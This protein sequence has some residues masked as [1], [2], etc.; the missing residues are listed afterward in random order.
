MATTVT[1]KGSTLTS[2]TNQTK[3]LKTAGKYMEDDVTITDATTVINNQDKGVTPIE[4]E[5]DIT[6]DTGYTGLG[7]VTV[8]A[9][10]STYVGR[11]ATDLTASGS[12]IT[13]P[14]GYYSSAVSKPVAAGTAT[15]PATTITVNPTISVTN[16]GVVTTSATGTSQI[17]PTIAAGYISA[18]TAGTITI[19]GSSTLTLPS[20]TLLADYLYNSNTGVL[21]A[22]AGVD[23]PYVQG[24]GWIAADAYSQSV[25]NLSAIDTNLT[26]AN[27][28]SGVSIFGVNGSLEGK[29]YTITIKTA[30]NT[31]N[32][33]IRYKNITYTTAG[34]VLTLTPGDTIY[35]YGNDGV[36]INGI[37]VDSSYTYTPTSDCDI[38]MSASYNFGSVS[39]RTSIIPQYYRTSESTITPSKTSK[40]ALG[41]STYAASSI[42]IAGDANLIAANIKSGVSIFGVNGTYA[43]GG[44]TYNNTIRFEDNIDQQEWGSI[45]SINV[46]ADGEIAKF[47]LGELYITPTESYQ[48]NYIPEASVVL[49]GLIGYYDVTVAPIPSV[50]HNTTDAT[51]S[52]A[53]I[54]DGK[55]AYGSNGLI[56]GGIHTISPL[57]NPY[58]SVA[59]GTY[60]IEEGY[61]DG[62]DEVA[63]APTEVA[64]LISDNIKAG[65]TILGVSGATNV[66]DT[67][68]TGNILQQPA[69][70]EDILQSRHAFINGASVSGTLAMRIPVDR[71]ISN[72]STVYTFSSGAYASGWTVQIS[73][74]EQ[75]KIIAGNIKSGV[76]IL[77]VTGTYGGGGTASY[78]DVYSAV[79]NMDVVSYLQSDTSAW[80][81]SLTTVAAYQFDDRNLSGAWHFDNATAIGSY[82]FYSV[83]Y[84][85]AIYASKCISVYASAFYNIT[86][87][88][89][90][91][92]PSCTTI[93]SN[94]FAYDGSL[95][96]L[97]IPSC[98]TIQGYAFYYCSSITSIYLPKV[99]T[100]SSYAFRYCSQ[101]S[102]IYAPLVQSIYTYAFANIRDVELAV[103][104][105]LATISTYAFASCFNLGSLYVLTSTVPTLSNANAFMSTP[106]STYSASYGTYGTI[107]V[108]SSMLTSFKAATN[109]KTYSARMVGLTDAQVSEVLGWFT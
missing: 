52:A 15:T 44:G 18:G 19:S 103:F 20:R 88:R 22:F 106:I 67:T 4:L 104:T 94:A 32:A 49:N 9:I 50:Y 56:S 68:Y 91:Y 16:A 45:V 6:Y 42:Y 14:A 74:T 41:S 62:N 66:I 77:G 8:G 11:I 24:G 48:Y 64:K 55:T 76:S 99:T 39:V 21:Q 93:Q 61:Y 12:I 43:A 59:S 89:S 28:K 1:Y 29:T 34:T 96:T 30:G 38:Y 37:D 7:T 84:M 3:V 81:N 82:A 73:A 13:A 105:S 97:S 40:I 26:A 79:A 86:S 54:L 63:I 17:A 70:A 10:S 36:E 53:D 90:V 51:A 87:L 72:Y 107:Y 75:A 25:I 71:T 31:T 85:T 69:S 78:Y 27:I 102:N 35:I 46:N 108:K 92:L 57:T 100:I 58:I 95:S 83:S 80:A 47:Q 101:A 5:Q 65:V 2:A 60:W 98:T 109:W 23:I 33:Y